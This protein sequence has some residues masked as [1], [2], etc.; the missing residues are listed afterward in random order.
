MFSLKSCIFNTQNSSTQIV[1][2][3]KSSQ[4]RPSPLKIKGDKTVSLTHQ[5]KNNPS[6]NFSDKRP[7]N[8]RECFFVLNNYKKIKIASTK[9]KVKL[10]CAENDC[11]LLK[12]TERSVSLSRY[13]LLELK[14]SRLSG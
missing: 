5:R 12:H 10:S 14:I 6:K 7:S 4:I 13:D 2:Y 9:K 3:I 11:R 1:L 8:I